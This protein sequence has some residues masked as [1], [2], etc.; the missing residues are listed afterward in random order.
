MTFAIAGGV[1]VEPVEDG[2]LVLRP[3]STGVLH[4]VGREAAALALARDGAT[5]VPIGLQSAMAGLVELGV[6]A[7]DAWSRRRVI[8]LGGVAAAAAVSVVALPGVAAAA[9]PSQTTRGTLPAP[10][11]AAVAHLV[12]GGGGGGDLGGGGGAGGVVTTPFLALPVG[13]H[14]VDVGA[15]GWFGPE[16]T[17]EQLRRTSGWRWW[18]RCRCRQQS[19]RRRRSAGRVR[20]RRNGDPIFRAPAMARV[21]T[22]RRPTPE[23]AVVAAGPVRPGRVGMAEPGCNCRSRPRSG[24][25]HPWDGSV[26]VAG[27]GT[28][29]PEPRDS[30]GWEAAPTEGL[31]RR[32]RRTP[33]VAAEARPIRTTCPL[34]GPGS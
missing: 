4:V 26:V 20:W 1:E 15:G 25:V 12:G 8:Q 16:R 9:S 28:S 30:V 13:F 17:A 22:A 2:W 34:V 27:E 5:A 18:D 33:A 21:M 29:V 24:S 3:G 23:T 14:F 10:T 19:R 11:F 6:V 31:T 7:T 32:L